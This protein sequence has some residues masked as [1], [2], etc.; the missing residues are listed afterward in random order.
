MPAAGHGPVTT[1]RAPEFFGAGHGRGSPDHGGADD[2][3]DPH[4]GSDFPA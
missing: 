1:I 4:R 2:G 3:V